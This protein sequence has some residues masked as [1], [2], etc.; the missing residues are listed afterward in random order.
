[1]TSGTPGAEPELREEI[2]QHVAAMRPVEKVAGPPV[3]FRSQA[4]VPIQ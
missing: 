4:A 3:P 1:M 2:A